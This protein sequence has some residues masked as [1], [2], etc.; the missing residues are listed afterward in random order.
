MI[1]TS[2]YIFNYFELPIICITN[3]KPIRNIVLFTNKIMY[4]KNVLILQPLG[5]RKQGY[6]IG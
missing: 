4:L 6:L 3:Y 5:I 1:G 2:K